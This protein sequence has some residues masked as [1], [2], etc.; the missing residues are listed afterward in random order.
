MTNEEYMKK[1]IFTLALLFSAITVFAQ[2][3]S[4]AVG[5]QLGFSQNIYRCNQPG[6][7]ALSKTNLN[8]FKVGAV[9]EG[10]IIKG[11][12]AYIALNYSYGGGSTKWAK[13]PNQ[14]SIYPQY[15]S[16]YDLHAIELACD[17]Q[18]KFAI[19]QNTYIILYTGPSIQ[20]NL[21][22]HETEWEKTFEGETKGKTIQVIGDRNSEDLAKTYKRINACWGVGAGFQYDRYY[23]R[24]GYDFGLVNPFVIKNFNEISG[25]EPLLTRGRQDQW[26]IK[27]GL[28]LWE[29]DN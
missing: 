27:L 16:R 17:W 22:L 11:F 19:A 28:Y 6:N 18:Y 4:C 25:N 1:T 14:E 10:T 20:C 15:R 2:E 9:F 21:S 23:I 5:L 13:L 8:G 7:D 3:S 24:G 26:A 12:G 29:S